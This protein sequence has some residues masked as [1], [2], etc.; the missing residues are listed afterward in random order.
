MSEGSFT[1]ACSLW[2]SLFVDDVSIN[3][4]ELFESFGVPQPL[5]ELGR[6]KLVDKGAAETQAEMMK[7]T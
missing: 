3:G 7:K 5:E 4:D 6:G 1:F 2:G